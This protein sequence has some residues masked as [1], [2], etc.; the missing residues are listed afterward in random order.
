[1][2]TDPEFHSNDRRH[3]ATFAGD[4]LHPY[5]KK[6]RMLG[7]RDVAERLRVCPATVY[8]LCASGALEHVRVLNSIRVP[9]VALTAFVTRRRSGG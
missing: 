4:L 5:F 2:E 6:S 3:N 1:L 8:K 9:E 7:V